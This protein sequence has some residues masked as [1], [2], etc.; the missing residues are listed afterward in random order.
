MYFAHFNLDVFS[1]LCFLVSNV[2]M[3]RYTRNR[4]NSMYAI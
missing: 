4:C 3:Q 1:Y 2:Q